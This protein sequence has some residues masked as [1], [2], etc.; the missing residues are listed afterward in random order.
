MSELRDIKKPLASISLDMDNFW[1]Y[2]KMHND[3]GWET[4]PSYFDRFIPFILELLH[5]KKKTI[6]FF[7][8]GQDASMKTHDTHLKSIV[9]NGHEVGN[10]SFKHESWLEL[11][12]KEDIQ[13]EIKKTDELLFQKTG[14][15]PVGFRGPGFSWSSAVLEVLSEYGY[16]YDSSAL[17]TYIGP[18]ARLYYFSKSKLSAGDKKKRKNLYGSFSR[19]RLSVQPFFW[20]LGPIIKLLEIP[21]TTIPFFK[22]PFHMSYL[23]YLSR[24]SPKLMMAYLQTAI[25][26]CRLNH[27]SPSFLLHPLDLMSGDQLPELSFFPGMDIPT[28]TKLALFHSVIEKLDSFFTLTSMRTLADNIL[29]NGN[30]LKLIYPGPDKHIPKNEVK[31]E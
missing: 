23:L 21:V 29:L 8:T 6:T 18:L 5:D 9:D 2:Q 15:K 1:A 24:I 30:R 11:Y 31:N 3:P 16:L 27:V 26:L 7:I 22:L 19:G 12:P 10:H 17:P 4:F 20:K 25:H 28:E 13:K 14:K